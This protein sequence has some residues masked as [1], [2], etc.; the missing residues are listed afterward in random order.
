[1]Y[2]IRVICLDFG[3]SPGPHTFQR[4]EGSSVPA[5]LSRFVKVFVALLCQTYHL[6]F[7]F[8]KC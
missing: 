5:P 8:A 4:S 3:P 2:F 6:C 1:M 7:I